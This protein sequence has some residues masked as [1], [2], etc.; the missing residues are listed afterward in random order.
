MCFSDVQLS[1]AYLPIDR[2]PFGSQTSVSEEQPAK[3]FS[4]ISFTEFGMMMLSKAH[5]Q[6]AFSPM[7]MI[8]FGKSIYLREQFHTQT[9]DPNNACAD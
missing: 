5:P 2:S 4:K 8:E 6:K 1:K 3:V 9:T 7:D